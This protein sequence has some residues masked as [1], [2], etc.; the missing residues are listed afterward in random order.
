MSAF[1]LPALL[2]VLIVVVQIRHGSSWGGGLEQGFVV[3]A[4][5]V[6]V[7]V[8]ARPVP[9]A[10]RLVLQELQVCN[11]VFARFVARDDALGVG[12]G[13]GGVGDRLLQSSDLAIDDG[14]NQ[15]RVGERTCDLLAALGDRGANVEQLLFWFALSLVT[16]LSRAPVRR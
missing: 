1:V 2:E 9:V 10:P 6:A 8:V 16:R 11:H 5:G 13:V 7:A 12:V 15:V 3:E 4:T 14:C